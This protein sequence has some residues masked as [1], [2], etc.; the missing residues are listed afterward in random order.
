MFHNRHDRDDA[1]LYAILGFFGI[2]VGVGLREHAVG[3]LV[4]ALLGLFA[5]HSIRVGKRLVR[6]A[7]ESDS[8]LKFQQNRLQY[9]EERLRH[10]NR[11]LTGNPAP[12]SDGSEGTPAPGG[13]ETRLDQLLARLE[14]VES[15]LGMQPPPLKSATI[16]LDKPPEE[17]AAYGD[18]PPIPEM[19]S[20]E[21][22]S[23]A[24]HV[25]PPK[26]QPEP[27][28][29]AARMA[30]KPV[31]VTPDPEMYD[32]FRSSDAETKD[33]I[34]ESGLMTAVKQFFTSGNVVARVGVVI[35]FFG[36]ALLVK[37]VS[38][39]GLLPIEWRLGAVAV[40]GVVLLR[41]GWN[42]RH[43]RPDYAAILQGA[44]VGTLYL[45]LFAA[46]KFY[47]LFPVGL[48]LTGMVL[49]VGFSGAVAVLQDTASLAVMGA[50]GGFLAPILTS[51]GG[52]SHVMLFSF[53]ALLNLGILGIAFFKAWRSLNLVGVTFT[54]G[55]ASLWG[56]KS[57]SPQFL[58]STEPFLLLYFLIYV[59]ISVLFAYR[60]TVSGRFTGPQG[61]VDSSLVFGV[62]LVGFTLQY[63]LVR[64]LEYGLAISALVMATFYVFL[65][66]WLWR[67]GPEH[68]RL[69][70]EAFLAL[71]IG[72]GSLAI[73]LALDGR[74]TTGTWAIEGAAMIW[75][76]VRQE[77]LV[78]RLFGV[79]LQVGAFVV[80]AH[81]VYPQDALYPIANGMFL[82]TLALS[83]AALFSAYHMGTHLERLH[84]WERR[85]ALP[86][87]Y[88]GL[89]LWFI[90]GLHEI[91]RF[92][93]YQWEDNSRLGFVIASVA[94]LSWVARHIAWPSMHTPLR[95][96]TPG[97]Y[98]LFLLDITQDGHPGAGM[99]WLLWPL[100]GVLHIGLLWH[101]RS[102]WPK[103]LLNW[104]HALGFWLMT[105]W[106]TW[107][108]HWLLDEVLK[109]N[110]TWAGTMVGVVPALV[111]L[112]V[113]W[114]WKRN[115][116]PLRRYPEAFVGR[117]CTVL[118]SWVLFWAFTGCFV[119]G[120]PAP[121]PYVPFLNP[122]ELGQL[123]LF[124]TVAIWIWRT[125][126][127]GM[128][129][130]VK[131]PAWPF[132]YLLG[133]VMFLALN[134]LIARSIHFVAKVSWSLDSLLDSFL[135][136]ASISIVWTL[137]ALIIT[138]WATSRNNRT[139][140]FIGGGLLGMVV[141][142]LFVFD[143]AGAGT[144]ARIVSFLVV[145]GLMLLIGYLSPLPPK[146]NSD[147]PTMLR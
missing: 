14:V 124:Y 44:G 90:N 86:L 122:V 141:L 13:I 7:T 79:L 39:A 59:A 119:E 3:V 35:L 131:I 50:I 52:G 57:Y 54:F 144:I 64:Q 143:L 102:H 33:S 73:P 37:F 53:Y 129:V 43:D 62:P 111:I 106:L 8:R 6:L 27:Q 24:P 31:D 23:V 5:A 67:R 61:Y 103:R 38:E 80:M 70:I 56:V 105:I 18:P 99:G 118:A 32:Q 68:M 10:L 76:G 65:S 121:L 81:K 125:R 146:S 30:A 84:V 36:V 85:F 147:T 2:L 69:I 110:D 45:T 120:N 46:A 137:L 16:V 17:A 75:I 109:V 28:S 107:E 74:W 108:A 114:V 133:G 123:F 9:L 136:H 116:W 92:V 1:M 34:R 134:S 140:W 98:L 72:F 15:R 12:V 71:G 63:G 128:P 19:V 115:I 88:W 113:L 42:L 78:P 132:S 47:H 117:G 104:W 83:L 21:E 26:T 20:S 138:V 55:I 96:Y 11:R 142:K 29:K 135:F 77:R 145:G 127:G 87:L 97:L 48:A 139:V 4:G 82:G 40:V 58:H 22:P 130:V 60:R 41:I 49:L 51:T 126:L 25:S 66:Q 100:S 95:F 112:W 94:A 93:S 101:Y 89:W 91:D